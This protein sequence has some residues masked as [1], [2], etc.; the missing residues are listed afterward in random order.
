M[1]WDDRHL[2]LFE[3]EDFSL[4]VLRPELDQQVGAIGG[5]MKEGLPMGATQG[6]SRVP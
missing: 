5:L 6:E 1:S 3:G 2:E 4:F